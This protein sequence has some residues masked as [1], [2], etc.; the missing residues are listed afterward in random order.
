MTENKQN[1]VGLTSTEA[2]RLQQHL[3][4]RV[5]GLYW[6]IKLVRRP[7]MEKSV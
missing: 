4:L 5:Q 7:G 3:L 6:L 1:M 2:N